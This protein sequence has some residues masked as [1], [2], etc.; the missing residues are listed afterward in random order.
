MLEWTLAGQCRNGIIRRPVACV[1]RNPAFSTLGL[2]FE[3]ALSLALEF[4][5][6]DRMIL[7]PTLDC[8]RSEDDVTGAFL[9]RQT[10]ARARL[11]LQVDPRLSPRLV[12]QHKETED[13]VY[14]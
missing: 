11:R 3:T 2:G 10:I 14:R 9:F 8:I 4:K 1:G 12:V 5:L 6:F 7:E 13:P